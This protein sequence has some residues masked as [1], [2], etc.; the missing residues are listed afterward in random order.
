MRKSRRIRHS[1]SQCAEL[2]PTPDVAWDPEFRSGCASRVAMMQSADH[3]ECDDLPPIGGLALAAFGGVLVE[4]EVGPGAVIVLEVLAQDA[5]EVLLSDNDDVVD[6]S[7]VSANPG[8]NA[9]LTITALA[10]RAM[11]YVPKK[12]TPGP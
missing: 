6:G 8:V 1:P 5:P 2:T 4:R 9:S 7:A 11:S 12:S 3:R 10:E